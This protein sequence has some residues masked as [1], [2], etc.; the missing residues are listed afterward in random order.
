[1]GQKVTVRKERV[2]GSG[3]A[4][5]EGRKGALSTSQVSHD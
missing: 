2:E 5:E 4:V 1:M 3:M